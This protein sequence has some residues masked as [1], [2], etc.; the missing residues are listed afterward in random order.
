[1]YQS[2][3][4]SP[5]F[6]RGECQYEDNAVG[7]MIS[8]RVKH[9]A[10]IPEVLHFYFQRQGSIAH[11]FSGKHLSDRWVSCHMILE[12]ANREGWLQKFLPEYEYNFT[13][14]FL[15]NTLYLVLPCEFTGKKE[16]I[17]QLVR[18]L[19]RIFPNFQSN[20]YYLQKAIPERRGLI[21]FLASIF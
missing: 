21:N 8:M 9:F 10:Y 3:Q 17:I 7:H 14:L 16:Y 6:R 12:I 20:R 18:E 13:T 4:E 15:I 5:A 1:M 19:K 2:S 11:S